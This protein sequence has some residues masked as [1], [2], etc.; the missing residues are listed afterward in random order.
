MSGMWNVVPH[1]WSVECGATWVECGMWYHMGGP[2][3]YGHQ[4][5][6]QL[7]SAVVSVSLSFALFPILHSAYNYMSLSDE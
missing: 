7:L 4:D 1:G 3:D 6:G 5:S 2:L